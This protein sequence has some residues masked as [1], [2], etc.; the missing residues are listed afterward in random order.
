MRHR[1]NVNTTTSAVHKSG[2]IFDIVCEHLGIRDVRLLAH[3]DGQQLHRAKAFL[4]RVL[5]IVER[6]N[7]QNNDD[8]ARPIAD[9][10]PNAGK[11]EFEMR[12]GRHITVEVKQPH[13]KT[14]VTTI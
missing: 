6:P 12:D 1:I 13:L 3:L 10:I 9:L 7:T 11:H 8:K 14:R 5:V 2:P 4:K